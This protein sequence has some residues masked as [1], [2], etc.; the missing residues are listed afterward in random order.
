MSSILELEAQRATLKSEL[1]RVEAALLAA[2]AEAS[3]FKVGDLLCRMAKRGHGRNAK[4]FEERGRVIKFRTGYRE[5]QAV[6]RILKKDGT[7]SQRERPLY[8]F[9]NWTPLAPSSVIGE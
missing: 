8:F 4:M 6:L 1:G 2:Q 5:A 3:S 7:D 9:E